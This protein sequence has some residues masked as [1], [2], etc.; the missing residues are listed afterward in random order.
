MAELWS[1]LLRDSWQDRHSLASS[2]IEGIDLSTF[3]SWAVTADDD[4]ASTIADVITA[5][6]E[7]P[8]TDE[9]HAARRREAAEKAV[10]R[11]RPPASDARVALLSRLQSIADDRGLDLLDLLAE[12]KASNNLLSFI[13]SNATKGMKYEA[14]AGAFI[15]N[16]VPGVRA[17]CLASTDSKL[18]VRFDKTG[19]AWV[20]TKAGKD[21]SKDA[22]LA[23]VVPTG[24]HTATVYLA[25]HK[26]ARIGGGHQDNQKAD[27][28]T[29]LTNAIKCQP[30]A[31]P[32]AELNKLA[33]AALG[34]PHLTITWE[35]ALILDGDYFATAPADLAT[36]FQGKPVL[37]GDTDSFVAALLPDAPSPIT[38]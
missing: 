9:E 25:S 22:D 24:E 15:E 12:A 35:P 5:A 4:F 16:R 7:T 21:L 33:A 3:L 8:P 27:A 18:S 13:Q 30:G 6:H 14:T 31:S 26:F 29:F 20:N 23:I 19:K 34:D 1:D 2:Y 10:R 28:H 32:L 11:L 36:T 17:L 38:I 37:I